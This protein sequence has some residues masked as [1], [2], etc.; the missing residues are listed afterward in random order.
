MPD[1]YKMKIS[2]GGFG[3]VYKLASLILRWS[4]TGAP[5]DGHGYKIITGWRLNAQQ[6]NLW[7]GFHIRKTNVLPEIPS[8][9]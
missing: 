9:I 2:L 8:K 3:T 5:T 1:L 6:G 4:R 7:L